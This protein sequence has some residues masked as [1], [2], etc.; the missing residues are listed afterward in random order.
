VPPEPFH[1][2]DFHLAHECLEGKPSA[3]E[4]LQEH[5]RQPL[6]AMLQK[7]H[8]PP[9]EAEEVVADLWADC[10]VPRDGRRPKL[11]H[12]NGACS[13]KTFLTGIL[14]N[15]FVGRR[16]KTQRRRELLPAAFGPDGAEV[17]AED[18]NAADTPAWRAEIPLLTLMRD[19]I[20]AA[21]RACPAEDFVL[22]QLAH[23]GGLRAVELAPMFGCTNRV[24]GERLKLAGEAI[25]E[26]T[27]QQLKATDPW[28]DLQWEDFLEMCRTASPACFGVD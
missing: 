28:L 26:T 9:H 25:N 3:L 5:Y 12:Y 18:A 11:A 8:A 17:K 23:L 27:R 14:L 21:F 22:L 6:L 10:V 15:D 4:H 1:H 13:L 19:A 7:S 2:H 16:R 20:E 24:I